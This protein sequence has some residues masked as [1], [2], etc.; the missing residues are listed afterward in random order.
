MA[1]PRRSGG[2]FQMGDAV[3]R[4][5]A[6]GAE[7]EGDPLSA[8][9]SAADPQGGVETSGAGR[10]RVGDEV[11]QEGATVARAEEKL[12]LGKGAAF[13]KG[14]PK[15][16]RQEDETWEADFQALPRPVTQ[17]QT[18]YLGM[19]VASDGSF[20]ADAH[21]EGRP[22]VNDVA[23]LLAQAMR[24]PLTGKAHRP[25]RLHLRGHPQWKELCPHLDE[26]GIKVAVHREL[27][28]VQRAYQGYLRQQ[29]DAHRFG[30]V[31][32]TAEQQGVEELFPA[33]AQWV[34][35][36]GH[37]EIGDQGM[38]G[39]VAR[40]LDYGGQVFEDDRPDTLAEALADLER[41]L[42]EYLQREGIEQEE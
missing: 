4:A 38:F 17:S 20:L 15:R 2:G 10:R 9:D 5:G 12:K 6:N 30:M 19:V 18:H 26:L 14:R 29:R 42:A 22:T 35:G 13:V 16:L 23:T 7:G 37:I 39:L 40:A 41:G 24:R 3:V 11:A 32:P 8:R 1:E 25:R 27:P 33:I 21:V 36:Y 34:R 28:K 31:R